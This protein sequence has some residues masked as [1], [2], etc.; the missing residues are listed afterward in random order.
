MKQ[1]LLQSKIFSKLQNVSPRVLIIVSFL[2]GY[3]TLFMPW[4]LVTALP[5]ANSSTLQERI[6]YVWGQ[7]IPSIDNCI[8]SQVEWSSNLLKNV[9]QVRGF[10][11]YLLQLIPVYIWLY[12]LAKNVKKTPTSLIIFFLVSLT[13]LLTPMFVLQQILPS[14]MFC[15]PMPIIRIVNISLFW[16]TVLIWVLSIIFGIFSLYQANHYN[17]LNRLD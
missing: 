10:F 4:T 16:P 6:I 5:I 11:E 14:Q 1:S 9:F 12:Y 7:E 8:V 2:L 17:K 13:L 3:A 15:D